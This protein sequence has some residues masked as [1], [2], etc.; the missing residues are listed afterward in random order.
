[1]PVFDGEQERREAAGKGKERVGEGSLWDFP[2][3]ASRPPG[4]ISMTRELVE[5]RALSCNYQAIDSKKT[6]PTNA[7]LY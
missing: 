2:L 1:M 7:L 6:P 5:I 3:A 4:L